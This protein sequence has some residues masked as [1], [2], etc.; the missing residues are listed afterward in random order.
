MESHDSEF[1][2][3]TAGQSSGVKKM[4]VPEVARRGMAYVEFQERRSLTRIIHDAVVEA[5]T[6]IRGLSLYSSDDELSDAE[7]AKVLSEVHA[8]VDVAH[9]Y[10]KTLQDIIGSR[11]RPTDDS[12]RST[13]EDDIYDGDSPF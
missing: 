5:D 12:M 1:S 7:Y 6:A 4:V 11:L 9:E 2:A 13:Y 10:L 3:G 8:C